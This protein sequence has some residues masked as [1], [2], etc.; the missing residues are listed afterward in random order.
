[1]ACA[2]KRAPPPPAAAAA[3]EPLKCRNGH[4]LKKANKSIRCDECSANAQESMKCERCD[5]DMCMKCVAKRQPAS[6]GGAAAAPVADNTPT[7]P[8]YKTST[9]E[10]WIEHTKERPVGYFITSNRQCRSNLRDVLNRWNEWSTDF[11]KN[12]DEFIKYSEELKDSDNPEWIQ[13]RCNS[14]LEAME[15]WI[16]YF[17]TCTEQITEVVNNDG[18]HPAVIA[19]VNERKRVL[20]FIK[21]LRESFEKTYA[22][23]FFLHQLKEPMKEI[24][25]IMEKGEENKD[26]VDGT[27]Y[28]SQNYD[29]G[30]SGGFRSCDIYRVA[31]KEL[32]K[33]RETLRGNPTGHQSQIDEV[34]KLMKECKAAHKVVCVEGVKKL[35]ANGNQ[36]KA[37]QWRDSAMQE[38]GQIPELAQMDAAIQKSR[39][40]NASKRAA[41]S[42]K[43]AQ[44]QKEREEESN[45][46]DE[47]MKAA[48]ITPYPGG[49]VYCEDEVWTYAADGEAVSAEGNELSFNGHYISG[50]HG[51]ANWNGQ[52]LSWSSGNRTYYTFK[53]NSGNFTTQ[54]NNLNVAFKW[55]GSVLMPLSSASEWKNRVVRFDGKVPVPVLLA[56]A[57]R[58]FVNRR[59]DELSGSNLCRSA[60]W[61]EG[62]QAKTCDKCSTN[63][64]LQC[65]V[66]QDGISFA[67]N[68]AQMCKYCA[69]VSPSCVKCGGSFPYNP[70]FLCDSCEYQFRG[71]CIRT[72]RH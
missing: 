4:E 66:C 19:T 53:L 57:L 18:T 62:V 30:Q 51:G 45:R 6:A 7:N 59:A 34:E 54:T 35:V 9:F 2:A 56:I 14:E 36:E 10:V 70:A 21:S 15:K 11:K 37:Q 32:E 60:L 8:N 43:A 72:T 50:A 67:R 38:L 58:K 20:G 25:Q 48:W 12:Y 61:N 65:A 71:N 28:L 40:E 1:M 49:K 42:A 31:I 33:V 41:E 3:P 16:P 52:T 24:R 29:F 44:E 47:E 26:F 13:G 46:Y 68:A 22:E 63:H 39:D 17:R 69:N 27:V 23:A 55:D 5:Y 64:K